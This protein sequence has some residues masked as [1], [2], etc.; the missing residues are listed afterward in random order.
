[1]RL[2]VEAAFSR[3]KLDHWKNCPVRRA[4]IHPAEDMIMTSMLHARWHLPIAKPA[5]WSIVDE[6]VQS[7]YLRQSAHECPTLL[8]DYFSQTEDGTSLMVLR[9]CVLLLSCRT[10]SRF[11]LFGRMSLSIMS[12]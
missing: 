5:D 9:Y 7:Q 2:A 4:V 10:L 8:F 1:M 11:A 6:V 12:D 3:A